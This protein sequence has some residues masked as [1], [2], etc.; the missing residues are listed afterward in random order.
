VTKRYSDGVGEVLARTEGTKAE[1]EFAGD[2]LYVRARV[3]S[4]ALHPNPSE[5]GDFQQAWV[6]PVV[7]PGAPKAR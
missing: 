7:G 1:Y 3:T 4:S 6:Q 2:E 5:P